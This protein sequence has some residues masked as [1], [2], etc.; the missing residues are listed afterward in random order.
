MDEVIDLV[1]K[2]WPFKAGDLTT[3]LGSFIAM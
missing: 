2:L 3:V 1:L